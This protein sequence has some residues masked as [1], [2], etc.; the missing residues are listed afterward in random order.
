MLTD[1]AKQTR[2]QIWLVGHSLLTSGLDYPV[3]ID[4]ISNGSCL[5]HRLV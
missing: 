4:A 1:Y 2:G 3:H 5:Q